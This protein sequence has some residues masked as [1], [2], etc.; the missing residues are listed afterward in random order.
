MQNLE[1]KCPE[2]NAMN[3]LLFGPNDARKTIPK[4]ALRIV[5]QQMVELYPLA[6]YYLY[7]ETDSIQLHIVE[8]SSFSASKKALDDQT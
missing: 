4:H 6:L 7:I 3:P 8:L 5:Y 1:P 2:K